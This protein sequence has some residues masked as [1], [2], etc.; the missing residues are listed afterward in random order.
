MRDGKMKKVPLVLYVLIVFVIFS[1]SSL[2][3]LDIERGNIKLVLHQGTGRFT[4]SHRS[5]AGG[6]KA[7]L[8]EQDPRTSVLSVL[9]GS[10]VYRVG[11]T[12]FF[13]ELIERTDQGAKFTWSSALVD[14]IEEF[15]FISSENSS[16]IDGVQINLSAANK[17]D[18]ELFVGFRYLLDTY[19]GEESRTHFVSS[20]HDKIDKE[21]TIFGTDGVTYWSSPSVSDS[22]GLKVIINGAGITPPSSVVFANWKR[23][24]EATWEYQ[25][26]SSRNFNLLPYSINDSAVC[27]YYDAKSIGPGL[28]RTV[29]LVMGSIALSDYKIVTLT[30]TPTSTTTTEVVADSSASVK[31]TD[32][33]EDLAAIDA[34]LQEIDKKIAEGASEEDIARIEKAIAELK[35]KYLGD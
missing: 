12:S 5:G 25:T 22:V 1:S 7:L 29:T 26:S 30:S 6:Y 4:I 10:K 24:N 11:E 32:L 3:C 9:V 33:I 16:S 18:R 2:F 14:I 8:L 34:M 28:S 35:K 23:L 17:T 27:Q 15:V 19:L 13:T 20:S 21:L 31:S